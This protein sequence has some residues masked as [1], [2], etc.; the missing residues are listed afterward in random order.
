[1]ARYLRHC[2]RRDTLTSSRA[3]KS[4]RLTFVPPLPLPPP[5][6]D[7]T[8]WERKAGADDLKKS[9][10]TAA[11]REKS[12][13]RFTSLTRDR[14][15]GRSARKR[16]SGAFHFEHGTRGSFW[17]SGIL[18]LHASKIRTRERDMIKTRRS[19]GS[20]GG[21]QATAV[22]NRNI[23]VGVLARIKEPRWENFYTEKK[24][25]LNKREFP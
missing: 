25:Y 3:I 12:Y 15:T 14:P 7:G 13:R 2:P 21:Q 18:S 6:R 23:L 10:G 8:R 19:G 24:T 16:A 5:R 9:S 20:P 1:M 4:V 11:P 22:N 17:T